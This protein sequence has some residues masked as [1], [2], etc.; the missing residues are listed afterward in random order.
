MRD[1]EAEGKHVVV[2][3][4]LSKFESENMLAFT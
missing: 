3:L 1:Y 2:Y 4:S